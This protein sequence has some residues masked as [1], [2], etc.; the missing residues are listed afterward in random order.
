[1]GGFRNAGNSAPLC[2]LLALLFEKP[3]PQPLRRQI[4]LDLNPRQ[5]GLPVT[6]T[7]WR[8]GCAFICTFLRTTATSISSSPNT[9]TSIRANKPL[10]P[11]A[12]RSCEWKGSSLV[13]GAWD[14][15]AHNVYHNKSRWGKRP[16]RHPLYTDV[17]HYQ[18][19]GI[20][21]APLPLP[22]AILALNTGPSATTRGRGR[23]ETM[24]GT[25]HHV[26]HALSAGP[27]LDPQ[28]PIPNKPRPP[29]VTFDERAPDASRRCVQLPLFLMAISQAC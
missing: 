17:P 3:L 4:R 14:A 24:A 18:W 28:A 11:A 29:A 25:R 2:H 9:S 26:P 13:C 15:H 21:S 5:T 1:M 22:R 7:R 8:S 19:P 10:K 23:F 20:P 6:G 12:A 27:P 16:R